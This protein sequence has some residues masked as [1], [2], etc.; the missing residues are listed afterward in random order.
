MKYTIKNGDEVLKSFDLQ[1]ED[2][3]P[4]KIIVRTSS[5]Q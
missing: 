1:F 5:S 4:V 3:K 2:V